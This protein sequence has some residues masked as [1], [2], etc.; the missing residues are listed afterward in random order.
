MK[1]SLKW[2]DESVAFDLPDR[3][4]IDVLEPEGGEPVADLWEAAWDLLETPDR[5]SV[6]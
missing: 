4:V 1:V 5:K 3:N 6:V 2:G